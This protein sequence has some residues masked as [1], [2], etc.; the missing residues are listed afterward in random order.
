[1]LHMAHS[2]FSAGNAS[3]EILEGGKVTLRKPRS[4]GPRSVCALGGSPYASSVASLALSG[5]ERC[6]ACLLPAKFTGNH[7]N[8]ENTFTL[9]FLFLYR[10]PLPALL[11]FSFLFPA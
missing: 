9:P 11:F 5:P 10:T 2:L 3:F 7:L 6:S 4:G 1:M 8:E